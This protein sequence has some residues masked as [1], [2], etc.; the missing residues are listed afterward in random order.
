M[1]HRL[2]GPSFRLPL[3]V[4]S[5]WDR[6][7]VSHRASYGGNGYKCSS[8]TVH[9]GAPQRGLKDPNRA[10]LQHRQNL[11]KKAKL[12]SESAWNSGPEYHLKMA[13]T[14]NW[15]LETEPLDAI[16]N[17]VYEW[18]FLNIHDKGDR[19]RK[20][21]RMIQSRNS[22]YNVASYRSTIVPLSFQTLHQ[23]KKNFENRHQNNVPNVSPDTWTEVQPN[24]FFWSCT[25]F[26]SL[27]LFQRVC[28]Q[29]LKSKKSAGKRSP[30]FL[31]QFSWG[32][33]FF[34]S[35][36]HSVGHS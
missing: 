7:N 28:L 32:N 19:A 22:G 36:E 21:F 23:T 20:V 15:K 3:R 26:A 12:Y 11:P 31:K 16:G 13:S 34:C 24:Q 1:F 6:R 5:F 18:H 17:E 35:L 4:S 27:L 14:W 10:I 29:S 9:F 2:G 33:S 25:L 8:H 30:L